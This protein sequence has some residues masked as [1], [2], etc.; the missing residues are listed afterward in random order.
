ED[1]GNTESQ[2]E[3]QREPWLSEPAEGANTV[4]S[5]LTVQEYFA[6][7]MA[8]LKASQNETETELDSSCPAADEALEPSEELKTKAKK[9]KKKQ[10]REEA[11][12][13]E[14]NEKPEMKRRKL[15]D[16]NGEELDA[17]YEECHRG[18]KKRKHKKE[19]EGE[20]MSCYENTGGGE[21]YTGVS[22]GEECHIKDCEAKE[23]KRRK[24][25]HKRQK[26]EENEC[27][28]EMQGKKKQRSKQV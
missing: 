15:G 28:V 22:D 7:R 24:K 23:K 16:L 18:K 19:H 26:E 13:T 10:K 2:E 11:E 3:K 1:V 21:I 5:S 27:K 4:K 20:S 12:N 14:N 25:K 8:K 6:K 9:K 17:P